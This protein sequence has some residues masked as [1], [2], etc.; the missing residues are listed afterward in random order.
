MSVGEGRPPRPKRRFGQHFLTD[1][2]VI[3]HIVTVIRPMAGQHIVEIGPGRG[4]LTRPLIEV[5]GTLEVVEIDRELVTALATDLCPLG[6]LR[7]HQSDA[8]R[9]D[10]SRLPPPGRRLRIVGNLPYN[11]STPLLFHLLAHSDAIEDMV[12]MLQRE[13]AE[14]IVAAPS[15]RD[16][17]RLSVMLQYRCTATALFPVAPQAF[18]PEPQVHSTVIR[19][20]PRPP[21]IPVA[22]PG[23]FERLVRKAFGQRRKK[24]RNALRGWLDESA[25]GRA[26]LDPTLRAETLAVADFVRLANDLASGP[27][28]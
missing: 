12:F 10:F 19:L 16:Y 8:L 25:F 23:L 6:E 22:D 1:P 20:V 15:T 2:S 26:G 9:F 27:D 11:I 13:V 4:A 3:E 17:G 5:L 7:V 14:R 18:R 21:A 24:L 28:R